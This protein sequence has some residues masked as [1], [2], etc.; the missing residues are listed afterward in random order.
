MGFKD[1]V[2]SNEGFIL[3]G[4]V[5]LFDI[6]V[7]MGNLVDK[8]D[9]LSDSGLKNIVYFCSVFSCDSYFFVIVY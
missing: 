4:F 7:V 9:W 6:W 5:E 8:E 2:L 3:S 1:I